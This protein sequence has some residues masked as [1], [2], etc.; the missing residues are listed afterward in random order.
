MTTDRFT[1]HVVFPSPGKALVT[2][3]VRIGR[4]Q[5]DEI[6][7]RSEAITVD[8]LPPAEAIEKIWGK[9]GVPEGVPDGDPEGDPNGDSAGAPGPPH[10]RFRS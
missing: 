4:R 1:A 10:V 9:I 2:L 5:L 3:T 8:G 6:L 7:A